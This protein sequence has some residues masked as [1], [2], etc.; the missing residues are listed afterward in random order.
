MSGLNPGA[1]IENHIRR[2]KLRKYFSAAGNKEALLDLGCGPR[3]YFDLYAPFYKRTIGADLQHSPFPKKGID[4]YCEATNVP[5]DNDSVD[6][7]LSTEVLHDIA[8]PGDFFNES[9]R[10]LR[11]GGTLVLTS[12]FV[13]PVVDGNYDHYRFTA[14]GLRYQAEKAGF[15]VISIEP[16]GDLF[17]VI[18]T[19]AVKPVLKLF[20]SISKLIRFSGFYSLYNPLL[21]IFAG[22]PQYLHLFISEIPLIRHFFGRFDYSPIGYVSIFQKKS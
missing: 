14:Q 16:I 20:N 3:P 6:T 9:H 21:F 18:I 2:K 13:V 11:S 5:L 12:P 4:L 15:E 17:A 1:I 19:L 22:L 7:V 8:E 10:L